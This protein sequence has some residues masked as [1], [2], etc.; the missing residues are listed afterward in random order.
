[1]NR[2]AEKS[3]GKHIDRHTQRNSMRGKRKN[4]EERKG[5]INGTNH[6]FNKRNHSAH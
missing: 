6:S 5:E 4:N 1:M 3:R 2:H